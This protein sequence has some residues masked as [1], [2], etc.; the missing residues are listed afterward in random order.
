MGPA[1]AQGA[2]AR[3]PQPHLPLIRCRQ[4]ALLDCGHRMP[5][6]AAAGQEGKNAFAEPISLL[7]IGVSGHDELVDGQGVIFQGG[8][9][10]RPFFSSFP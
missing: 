9:G 3:Y 7:E 1:P 5:P 8:A 6:V 10:Y 4:T 2:P